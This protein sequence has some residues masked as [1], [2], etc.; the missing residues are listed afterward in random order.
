MDELYKI[1][2]V[3]LNES[4]TKVRDIFICACYTGL[5]YTYIKKL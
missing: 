2:D 5:S 3:V 1:T 4:L